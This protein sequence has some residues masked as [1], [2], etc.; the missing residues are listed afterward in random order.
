MSNHKPRS[1]RSRL[2]CSLALAAGFALSLSCHPAQ[3]TTP[4]ISRKALAD[5]IRDGTAPLIL[6]VRSAAEYQSGHIPGSVNIPHDQLATRL[7]ELGISK[8]AEVVVHCEGGGRASKAEAILVASGYTRV[9]DL[10]GHMK[11]W[12]ESGLPVE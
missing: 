11:G 6:D 10:E 8:S 5:E 1:R 3:V 9:V 7:S 2:F 4:S 12:R